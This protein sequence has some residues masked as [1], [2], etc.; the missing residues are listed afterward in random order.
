MIGPQRCHAQRAD[1]AFRQRSPG[2]GIDHLDEEHVCPDVD[3]VVRRSFCAHQAGFAHAEDVEHFR[4]PHAREFSRLAADSVSAEQ[5]SLRTDDEARSMPFASARLAR[6]S[7]KLLMPMKTVGRRCLDQLE[8]SERRKGIAGADPYH[9]DV[10]Q[11]GAARPDLAGRMDA[12]RKGDVAQVARSDADARERTGPTTIR[13]SV[14]HPRCADKIPAGR[15]SRRSANTRRP[16]RSAR[17]RGCRETPHGRIFAACPCRGSECFPRPPWSSSASASMP[18][19]LPRY[20]GAVLASSKACRL[21]SR[22]MRAI[23]SRDSGQ[24]QTE[25][26]TVRSYIAGALAAA[27]ILPDQ[28]G[29]DDFPRRRHRHLVDDCQVLRPSELGELAFGQEGLEFVEAQASRRSLAR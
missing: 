18:S 7:A 9:A 15:S 25:N 1:F 6:C 20:Q 8:L 21:R 2:G 17:C 26:L 14:R 29:L 11:A 28:L 16:R 19:S 4:A 10:E 27:E 24:W 3:A 23:S 12:K 5:T 13:H 22:W